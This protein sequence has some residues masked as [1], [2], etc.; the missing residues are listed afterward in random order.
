M[1]EESNLG[2][3]VDAAV[4]GLVRRKPHVAVHIVE[5]A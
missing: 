5:S 1:L 2:P 4:E 3:Y